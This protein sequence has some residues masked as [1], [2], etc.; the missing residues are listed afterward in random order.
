M[1]G[2]LKTKKGSNRS[3][4]VHHLVEEGKRMQ[5]KARKDLGEGGRGALLEGERMTKKNKKRKTAD[6]YVLLSVKMVTA[7]GEEERELAR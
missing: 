2:R 5:I 7:E 3:G 4:R 1:I 6:E